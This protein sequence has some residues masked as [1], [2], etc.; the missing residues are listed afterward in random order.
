[1]N[2]TENPQPVKEL[3]EEDYLEIARLGAKLGVPIPLAH[4]VIDVHDN[5]TL[6]SHYE[7][8][9]RSWN[10]NFW[11]L[12]LLIATRSSGVAT[13]FGAG[14]LSVKSTDTTVSALADFQTWPRP[15]G[16]VNISTHGIQAGIGTAAESFEGYVLATL[17]ANGTG[18]NQLVYSAASALVQ[19]YVA[20][21]KTWTVTLKRLFN[22]NSAADILVTEIAI[23]GIRVGGTK[24]DMICRD[25]LAVPQNVAVGL[26]LTIQYPITLVFPA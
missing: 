12:I 3:N 6:I 1:M 11:N 20:G 22:N 10:R 8:R 13:N 24:Y 15:A 5:N 21:T 4:V 16:D 18:A 14:Y 19:D 25:L 7:Q 26:Q 2:A 9:S 17:C 23:T